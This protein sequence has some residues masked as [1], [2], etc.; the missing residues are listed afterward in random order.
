MSGPQQLALGEIDPRFAPLR[1]ATPREMTRLQAQIQREQGIRDPLLVSTGVEPEHWVLVDGF[2]RLRVARDM[3]LTYLWVQTQPLDAAHAKAAILQ[4][5]QPREGLCKL[6]EAWI[7]RSL[8]REQGLMQTKIAELLGRDKSWVCR[9]LRIAERLQESLQDDVRQGLLPTTVACNLSR[10]HRCNQRPVAQV[11]IDHQLS[12]RESSQLVRRL[13]EARKPEDQAVR[14]MLEDPWRYIG[15]AEN[16]ARPT[17][18]GDSRLSEDGNRLRRSLLRWKRACELLTYKL[19]RATAADACALAPLLQDAVAA[20]M[21]ALQQLQAT[22]RSCNAQP[23]MQS[24][25]A[26]VPGSRQTSAPT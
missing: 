24:E 11:V 25:Q 22:E 19:Q 8:H 16:K 17:G 10:L 12:T 21:Q 20:G 7:V 13:R 26:C 14:E 2:K 5:N 3:G 18:D 6:E 1:L 23:P 15:A 9:R 4:C